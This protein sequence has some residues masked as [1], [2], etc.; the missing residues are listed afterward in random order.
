MEAAPLGWAYALQFSTVPTNPCCDLSLK[1]SVSQHLSLHLECSFYY[2]K[3]TFLFTY[4]VR[5]EEEKAEVK[6]H[7][8]SNIQ[9]RTLL[10]EIKDNPNR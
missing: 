9:Q 6:Q 2:S 8:L 3:E 7:A 4:T 1:L 10:C 5:K